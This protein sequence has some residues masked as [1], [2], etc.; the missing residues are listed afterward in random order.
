MKK[1]S[2]FL[3]IAIMSIALVSC[4]NKKY[5]AQAVELNS[6]N[7]SLNFS[8]GL[9]LGTQIEKNI[10]KDDNHDEQIATFIESLDKYYSEDITLSEYEKLGLQ[11]G[12]YFK[13]LSENGLDGR[14]AWQYNHNIICQALINSLYD[15]K[16]NVDFEYDNFLQ[17]KFALASQESQPDD[18]TPAKINGDC[19]TTAADVDLTTEIDSINY[20]LGYLNGHFIQSQFGPFNT[21]SIEVFTSNFNSTIKNNKYPDLTLQAIQMGETF[22]TSKGLLNDSTIPFEYNLVRQGLINGL[23]L[24]SVFISADDAQI[25]F[26]Q[27]IDE[28]QKVADENNR[29]AGENYLAENAKRPEVKT[30]P[31]GL[32]YEVIKHG[33]GKKHPKETSTVT[34]HYHGTLI[35]GTVFDSSVERGTPASF[36]LNGVI[37]GWTEGV[38]LMVEG[39]Q[40][41]FYIPYNLAYGERETGSIKPY[42]ALIFDVELIEI[43]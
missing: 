16:G 15:Y 37:K 30:T 11:I 24:D 14:G 34:V 31:S 13:R 29:I 19:P 4:D 22:K 26:R 7:D 42:S 18:V 1:I 3:S 27:T 2:V 43:K 8:V 20:A 33:K 32:Q 12:S 40:F 28:R 39:D 10:F 35:D 9:L 38:Q 17:N 25:Y 36:P 41:R 6:Q 23:N 21:D 5:E